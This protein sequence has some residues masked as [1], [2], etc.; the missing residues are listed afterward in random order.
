MQAKVPPATCFPHNKNA[1][2]I[3]RRSDTHPCTHWEKEELFWGGCP[4]LS[5]AQTE[6]PGFSCREG[7]GAVCVSHEMSNIVQQCQISSRVVA[8]VGFWLFAGLGSLQ[9]NCVY[10]LLYPEAWQHTPLLTSIIWLWCICIPSN[11][12][13]NTIRLYRLF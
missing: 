2:R 12:L 11:P 3:L 7:F 13:G 4:L 9:C 8:V 10:S 6:E 5:F 1:K